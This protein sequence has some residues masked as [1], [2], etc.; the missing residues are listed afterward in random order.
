M[1]ADHLGSGD[2]AITRVVF[3]VLL[4][5]AAVAIVVAMRAAHH[6]NRVLAL[7]AAVLILITAVRMH[8]RWEEVTNAADR[9]AGPMG[10]DLQVREIDRFVTSVFGGV[11]T[12]TLLVLLVA[13]CV[14]A[15]HR[16]ASRTA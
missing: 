9:L 10:S 7:A 4:V 6:L 11:T 5:A 12:F 16:R 14:G 15:I 1:L 13:A 2:Y 3:V 8:Q